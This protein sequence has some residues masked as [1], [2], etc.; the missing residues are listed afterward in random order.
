M[1]TILDELKERKIINDVVYEEDLNKKLEKPVTFYMGIDPTGESLH[2]GHFAG[3]MLVKRLQQA[4]HKPILLMGGGTAMIGDPS[5][6]SD[7]RPMLSREQ[8]EHNIDC[9]KKQISNFIDFDGDNGARIV[10]NADWLLKLNYVDFLRE[11]GGN[12]S[13][14]KMLAC[15]CFKTRMEKGLSFLEFN[16]MPMQSYDFYYLFNKYG[17][18]LEVGGSDQWANI[19]AG[20]DLIRRKTGKDA[21][22]FTIKLLLTSEGKKMGKTEKGA[23]FLDAAKT[24]PY[25]MFQFLR[26]VKDDEVEMCLRLLTLVP[27]EQINELVKFKD[28]R[29]NKAKEILAYE[30]VKIVHGEAEAENTLNKVKN[31]FSGGENIEEVVLKKAENPTLA[32]VLVNAGITASKGEARRLVAQSGIKVDGA[33]ATDANA[34]ITKNEIVVQKGKKVHKKIK[35]N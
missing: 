3:L 30:V 16:Y 6:K 11:V 31:A 24:S 18:T 20:A 28:E 32:D 23:I 7:M 27:N 15:D 4:G 9:I 33:V 12:L 26:N 34:K 14:N 10:N 1:K 35:F 19:L 25:E 5:F 22:A 29:I 8:I 13:V 17:C 2:L 21:Y